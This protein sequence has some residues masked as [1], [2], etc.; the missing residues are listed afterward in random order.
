M[1]KSIAYKR[2]LRKSQ[3]LKKILRSRQPAGSSRRST[4]PSLPRD[5]DSKSFSEIS[6]LSLAQT[7][8]SQVFTS[9][10]E[11]DLGNSIVED[12]PV[13][14]YNDEQESNT[15]DPANT[16]VSVELGSSTSHNDEQEAEYLESVPDTNYSSADNSAKSS[17]SSEL[18]VM[19]AKY[20][21]LKVMLK[22]SIQTS[23]HFQ[24]ELKICEKELLVNDKL[25]EDVQIECRRKIL[26]YAKVSE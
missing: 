4:E 11:M 25:L 19:K 18:D 21:E 5:E 8:T 13:A 9:T 14:V 7:I 6:P 3:K 24:K 26:A 15:H 16:I 1:G 17:A 2:R 22:E 12:G 23:N 20:A 10:K